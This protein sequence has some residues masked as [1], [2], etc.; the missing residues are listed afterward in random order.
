MEDRVQNTTSSSHG[1]LEV[2]LEVLLEPSLLL[3]H[4]FGKTLLTVS[5]ELTLLGLVD[6]DLLHRRLRSSPT[7][8]GVV[9]TGAAAAVAAVRHSPHAHHAAAAAAAPAGEGPSAAAAAVGGDC[10]TEL[11][12]RPG[13]HARTAQDG[14]GRRRRRGTSRGWRST[15]TW[16]RGFPCNSHWNVMSCLRRQF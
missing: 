7:V 12:H 2:R 4:R 15:G 3:L 16:R 6:G 1:T 13:R 14:L 5:R 8:V 11:D 10:V 9:I